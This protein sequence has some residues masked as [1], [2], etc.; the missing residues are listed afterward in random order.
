MRCSNC[1]NDNPVGSRFCNQCGVPLDSASAPGAQTELRSSG[2][3]GER[4]HLTVLFCD[5]VN[6]T[7]LAT[8]LDPEEWREIIADYHRIVATA[9]ERFGGYVASYLGDGVMAY[10]GW[11]E[12]HDNAAE[13]A[14]RAGLSIV[15]DVAKLSRQPAHAKLSARVGIDSGVVCG[16]SGGWKRR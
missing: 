12:A 11:P 3:T 14:A 8:S 7:S 1:G 4:R 13:R 15:E 2:L 16:R 9:I 6:S 10:F 5:L